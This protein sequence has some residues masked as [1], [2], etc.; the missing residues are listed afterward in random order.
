MGSAPASVESVRLDPELRE[1]LTQRAE[2]DHETPLFGS[3]ERRSASTSKS[4]TTTRG[5]IAG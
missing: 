5:P 3:S 4:A 1:P 2:R